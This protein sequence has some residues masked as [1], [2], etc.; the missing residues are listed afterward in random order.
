MAHTY[1]IGFGFGL[2]QFY[3]ATHASGFAGSTDDIP[4]S[5]RDVHAISSKNQIGGLGHANVYEKL[6]TGKRCKTFVR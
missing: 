2:P 1:I 5:F 4:G 6:Q 3:C